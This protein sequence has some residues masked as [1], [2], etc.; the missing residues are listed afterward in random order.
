MGNAYRK[1]SKD[2]KFQSTLYRTFEKTGCLI[3]ADSREEEKIQL[4]DVPGYTVPP[5][6][7]ISNDN[8][9]TETQ[10]P[11]EVREDPNDVLPESDI[12]EE[13]EE[14]DENEGNKNIFTGLFE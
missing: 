2:E 11:E 9:D 7:D 1:A 6:V 4:E 8:D 10:I 12:G 5:P 3:T 13:C 14:A